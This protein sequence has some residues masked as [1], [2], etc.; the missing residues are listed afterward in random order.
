MPKVMSFACVDGSMYKQRIRFS[1]LCVLT[2]LSHFVFFRFQ[3][4]KHIENMAERWLCLFESD[5]QLQH[6]PRKAVSLE[7]SDVKY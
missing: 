5:I 6:D 4:P 1:G 3:K 7:T 2:L